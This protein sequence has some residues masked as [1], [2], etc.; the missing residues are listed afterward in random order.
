[1]K[2]YLSFLIAIILFSIGCASSNENSEVIDTPTA[3]NISLSVDETLQPIAD[4]QVDVFQHQYPN[5]KINIRYR[6]EAECVK[7]LYDDSCKLIVLGR[8]LTTEELTS[9]KNRNMNP[10]HTKIATDAIAIITNRNSKDTT[11]TYD[12]ILKI[13]RGQNGQYNIVFDNQN[14]GTVS[15]IL[16][17]TGE[18]Q[19]PANAYAAKS[20]L[21]AVNYVATHDKAIGVIGWSWISDSDDP[22]TREYLSAVR[23]VSLG[24]KEAKTT[25]TYK[26]YQ[27]N[28][29][30]GKYPLSREVFIIQRLRSNGLSAGFNAFVLSEIGQTIILKAGLLPAHQQDRWIE[31]TT[32]PVGKVKN[33]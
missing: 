31:M 8:Q 9:F 22:K 27:L 2:K 32:K 15:Y 16:G 26:P 11:F 3:G 18:K 19:M 30:Q 25:E 24:T 20:N 23:L 6:S 10:P 14:S 5:A 21:E 29:A 28:L 33:N 17:M 12:Q 1:M 13:L 7:D 4:A